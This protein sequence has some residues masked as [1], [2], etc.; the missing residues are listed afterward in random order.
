MAAPQLVI[1]D[2]PF[3]AYPCGVIALRATDWLGP[4]R[5]SLSTEAAAQAIT[6]GAV[7]DEQTVSGIFTD[8]QAAL[9]TADDTLVI[10]TSGLSVEVAMRYRVFVSLKIEGDWDSTNSDTLRSAGNDEFVWACAFSWSF[11]SDFTGTIRRCLAQPRR[12][13]HYVIGEFEG[14]TTDFDG[15]Q[16][17]Y[18]R[19]AAEAGTTIEYLIDQVFL[20]PFRFSSSFAAFGG[21]DSDGLMDDGPDGGDLNGKFTAHVNPHETRISLVVP[22]GDYQQSPDEE[23]LEYVTPVDFSNSISDNGNEVT[24]CAYSFHGAQYREEGSLTEDFFGRTEG[25]E[26]WGLTPEGFTWDP[27]PFP[28]TGY[29]FFTDGAQGVINTD[30]S[31]MGACISLNQVG[32][33]GASI[34]SPDFSFSGVFSADEPTDVGGAGVFRAFARLWLSSHPAQRSWYVHLDLLAGIWSLHLA[35]SR[36]YIGTAIDNGT[37]SDKFAGDFTIPG[38]AFGSPVG[39]RIEKKRYVLKVRIWDATGAEPSTWD[40]EDFMPVDNASTGNLT[41]VKDYPYD[42]DVGYAHRASVQGAMFPSVG[43]ICTDATQWNTYWDDV[44]VEYDPYG[45]PDDVEV[46]MTD[47]NGTTLGPITIPYGAQQLVYWGKRDWTT[48]DGSTPVLDFTSWVRNVAGAAQLQRA[49]ALLYWFRASPSG[50]VSM[51]WRRAHRK[52]TSRRVL[53]GG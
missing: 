21:I 30:D 17:M 6:G 41:A 18:F 48:L 24:A 38:W 51:N 35:N 36:T 14:E 53:T 40:F 47:A 34:R 1:A 20:V 15:T 2:A 42:D 5:G 39:F 28:S 23:L 12:C 25:P 11:Q 32:T 43:M 37:L 52:S 33:I 27:F 44:K 10:D 4:A 13:P 3:K 16:T 7:R 50:I 26:S 29:N 45:N 49:E 46:A 9:Q 8:N 19:A 22:G 31:S